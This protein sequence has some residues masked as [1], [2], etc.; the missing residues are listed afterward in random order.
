MRQTHGTCLSALDGDTLIMVMDT[1]GDILIT[2]GVI[3]V[4]DGDILDTAVATMDTAVATMDTDI[5][6]ITP[7]ILA[8]EVLT[9]VTTAMALQETDTLATIRTTGILQTTEHRAQTTTTPQ[10]LVML[11]IVLPL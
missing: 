10:Q 1:D 2:D 8:E 7:T 11:E 6:I 9:M 4:T 3:L 5:T